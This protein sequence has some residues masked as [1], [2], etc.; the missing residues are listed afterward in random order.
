M[1][2][3]TVEG[4]PLFEG[5]TSAKVLEQLKLLLHAV[6]VAEADSY[7]THDLRRGHA[8]DLQLSG[9]RYLCDC[10]GAAAVHYS[11]GAN[12]YEILAAGEWRSCAFLK[13]R[14]AL[15]PLPILSTVAN[16]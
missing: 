12:L 7:R 16:L 11:A 4:T 5:M 9:K 2:N 1:V 8:K 6:G 14:R 15:G 3:Q 13:A 10:E